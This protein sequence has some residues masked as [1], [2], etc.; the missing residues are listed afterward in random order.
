MH[1]IHHF[2][3]RSGAPSDSGAQECVFYKTYQRNSKMNENARGTSLKAAQ[4]GSKGLEMR[5]SGK[6]THMSC[7]RGGE[8]SQF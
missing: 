6:Y 4:Y 2:R 8:K 7:G 1:Y 5:N 3:Q